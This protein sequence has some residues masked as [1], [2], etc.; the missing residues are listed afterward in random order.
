M[1]QHKLFPELFV[2][3]LKVE[4]GEV[5]VEVLKDAK[6]IDLKKGDTYSFFAEGLKNSFNFKGNILNK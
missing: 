1:Y 6:S 4:D 2:K 5:Y 3:V